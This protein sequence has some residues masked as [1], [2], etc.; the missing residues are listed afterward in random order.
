MKT[1]LLSVACLML[2]GCSKYVAP[3]YNNSDFTDAVDDSIAK[4][5]DEN[6]AHYNMLSATHVKIHAAIK[7]EMKNV[8]E[9]K[10]K[11]VVDCK[12]WSKCLNTKLHVMFD[13]HEWE[14]YCE[15][16]E[17]HRVTVGSCDRS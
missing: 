12:A 3:N 11:R 9:A 8:I 17:E 10:Q 15:D 5:L 7:E 13:E 6:Q 14:W 2:I 16:S 1:K 4:L